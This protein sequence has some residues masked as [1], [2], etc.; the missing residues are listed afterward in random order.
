VKRFV[1]TIALALAFA[2]APACASL[3]SPVPAYAS[4][5]QSA[6]AL[7]GAY[8]LTLDQATALIANPATPRA[9][10]TALAE[11]EKRATPAVE[12]VKIAAIAHRRAQNGET[13]A[14]LSRALTEAQAP[15]QALAALVGR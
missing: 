2:S 3:R 6:L 12:L 15:A 7:M 8:A 10:K 11:A 5:E 1:R 4:I 9:V 14:A 13:G